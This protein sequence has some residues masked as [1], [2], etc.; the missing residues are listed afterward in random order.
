LA[1]LIEAGEIFNHFT[2]RE[3]KREFIPQDVMDKVWNR[4]GGKCAK[5]GSQENLEFDHIIPFSKGG[6]SLTKE[7]IRILCAKHN[8]EKSDKIMI[9]IPWISVAAAAITTHRMN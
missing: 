8:L 4:D 6:S 1:E 7:N 9:L 5:C 3:G 2:N